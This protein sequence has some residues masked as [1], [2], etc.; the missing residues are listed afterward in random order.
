MPGEI[1][2]L[3]DDDP[4]LVEAVRAVLEQEY[5]V[6]TAASGEEA[7]AAIADR[8]PDLAI[9]DVMMTYPSEGYD[10]ANLIRQSPSTSRVPI[11]MLT[12]VD[13]MFD[14]RLRLEKSKVQF[15]AFLTKP[16]DLK[17]LTA[18]ISRLL[19]NRGPRTP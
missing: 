17:E 14:L 2:L 12:G 18:T 6:M 4:I 3:V 9:L 11:I 5:V 19:Q 10:L 15:D 13:K 8:V 16:P 1:I 7:M